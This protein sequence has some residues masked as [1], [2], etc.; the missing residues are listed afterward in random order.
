MTEPLIAIEGKLG[1]P[2][3]RPLAD[4]SLTFGGEWSPLGT[5]PIRS[6]SEFPIAAARLS[7]TYVEAVSLSDV[8]SPYRA[9]SLWGVFSE[10]QMRQ[11][12]LQLM[13][14]ADASEQSALP[15][16]E[17]APIPLDIPLPPA[18]A[19]RYGF[20]RKPLRTA[21]A[22]A[23]AALIAW[24]LFGHEPRPANEE[25]AAVLSASADVPAKPAAEKP[26]EVLSAG[27][28]GPAKPLTTLSASANAPA[29]PAAELSA[30]ADAS[31]KPAATLSASANAPEKPAATL[32][33]S[34]HAPA[35]HAATLSASANAPA[36][37]A[38]ALS[39]SAHAPVKRSTASDVLFVAAPA[40][41]MEAASLRASALKV[42]ARA[43][44]VDKPKAEAREQRRRPQHHSRSVASSEHLERASHVAALRSSGSASVTH[45]AD[46][47]RYAAAPHRPQPYAA[48]N[49]EALYAV[50][51]HSPTLDSN[52]APRLERRPADASAN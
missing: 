37:H 39:A 19:D 28:N 27:A 2:A 29:K 41:A 49:V 33:A 20:M 18:E 35:K 25:P 6:D 48:M 24:L 10:S 31:A 50:L 43:M 47:P 4:P 3:L 13:P 7:T 40:V 34:A 45:K 21:I 15:R 16:A 38:V 14:A 44:P 32:S 5:R 51:Q 30:S 52:A 9:A 12:M 42:K 36:K 26:A 8:N 22:I 46:A 17:A 23:C 11:T 1:M